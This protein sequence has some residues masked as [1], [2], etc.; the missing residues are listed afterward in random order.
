MLLYTLERTSDGGNGNHNVSLPI[1]AQKVTS[2]RA[3]TLAFGFLMCSLE[4]L[5][6]QYN[7]IISISKGSFHRRLVMKYNNV[8]NGLAYV[9]LD[10]ENCPFTEFSWYIILHIYCIYPKHLNHMAI[11]KVYFMHG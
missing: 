6:F 11:D 3:P 5:F 1:T 7:E 8:F 10:Y 2:G 4:N 9:S